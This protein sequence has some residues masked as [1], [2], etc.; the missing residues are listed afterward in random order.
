MLDALRA[1]QSDTILT[2]GLGR[3][4]KDSYLKLKHAEWRD[5]S[6]YVTKWETDT[7]LDC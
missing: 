2:A 4:F 1:F 5:F 6:S 3:E 7:T